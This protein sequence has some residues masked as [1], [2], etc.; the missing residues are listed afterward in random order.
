[1]RDNKSQKFVLFFYNDYESLG[2]E[3]IS[4]VLKS[5]NIKTSLIYRN[6]Q[7][8]YAV[9]SVQNVK[10]QQYHAIAMKICNLNPDVLAL[11][12]L[13]DTFQVN[14]NVAKEVKNI[15]SRIKILVGG[16]HAELLPELTLEYPQV[17]ALCIGEGEYSVLAFVQNLD[18]IC[19]GA[20][21]LVNGVVYKHDGQLIGS[22]TD[23]VLNERLDDLPFPDKELFYNEEPSMKSHYF[24]QT[25][26]GCPYK[27]SFCI[28]DRLYAIAG[29]NYLRSRSP[30]NIINELVMAKKKYNP[31][32]VGFADECFGVKK[33]WTEELLSLYKKHVG[34]P[35]LVPLHPNLVN[36]KLVDLL[37]ESNCWYVVMGV[38]SLNP[39]T[40]KKI[41]KRPINLDKIAN[42]IKTIRSRGIFLQCD[43]IMGIQGETEMDMVKALS[44]YNKN[45]PSFVSV[46]W[47]A[48]YPKSTITRHARESGILSEHVLENIAH[49]RVASGIKQVR[50]FYASNFWFNYFTFFPRW[51]ISFIIKCGIYRLFKIK[52][53]YISCALPRLVRAILNKKNW[54]RYY[55]K[56]IIKK[57]M[58]NLKRRPS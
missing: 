37:Q 50:G 4:A 23:Y 31:S 2:I 48:Y 41:L 32:F 54:D 19:K 27:C 9:E 18:E 3:Y 35:F 5:N 6:L 15:N 16:V 10:N 13:T 25:T 24:I 42:A 47:L 7:D 43:H 45:R 57:K 58:N 22:L 20:R 46:F 55:L 52:S 44:F 11:S 40:A 17:D 56:Q 39:L 38:Q 21:P 29:S 8:F 36:E 12:I 49:G 51:F 30:E 53:F 14:M 34:L 1:M 26:R 33:K 28:N